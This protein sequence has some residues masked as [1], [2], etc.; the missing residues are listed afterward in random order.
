MG[1]AKTLTEYFPVHRAPDAMQRPGAEWME[2]F[3]DLLHYRDRMFENHYPSA[4][5]VK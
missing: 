5:L 4:M 3:G 2:R 1:D